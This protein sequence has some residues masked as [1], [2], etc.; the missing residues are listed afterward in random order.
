MIHSLK[1][2]Y[3]GHQFT[4]AIFKFMRMKLNFTEVCSLGSHWTLVQTGVQNWIG[5]EQMTSELVIMFNGLFE[6]ADIGV[7][8]VQT[9]RVIIT[10]TLES[11]S[12][13]QRWHNI[14][15]L[16]LTQEKNE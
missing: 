8:V 10:C 1:E 14:Y 7:H 16:Q 11:L 12:P 5:A 6:T 9:S 13:Y 4:D 2:D 15:R 3:D